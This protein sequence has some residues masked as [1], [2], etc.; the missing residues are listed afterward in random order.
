MRRF[1]YG[2]RFV[3]VSYRKRGW[4]ISLGDTIDVVSPPYLGPLFRL[5]LAPLVSDQ[6]HS[7]APKFLEFVVPFLDLRVVG[8]V[9]AV[10]L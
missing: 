1:R 3:V 10:C 5:C 8:V 4:R 9:F 7:E 2:G 6:G